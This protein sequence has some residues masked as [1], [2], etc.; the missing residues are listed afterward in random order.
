[1]TSLFRT[2]VSEF[3]Q[4]IEPQELHRGAAQDEKQGQVTQDT[5]YRGGFAGFSD[6]PG[7]VLKKR[8]DWN[9]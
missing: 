9:R 8:A 6:V 1:M 2:A 3:V 4:G 5:P 7:A